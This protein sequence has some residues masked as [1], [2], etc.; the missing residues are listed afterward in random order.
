MAPSHWHQYLQ[1]DDVDDDH[2][3]DVVRMEDPL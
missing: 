3:V 1:Y 2:H